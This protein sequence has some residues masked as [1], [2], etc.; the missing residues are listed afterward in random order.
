MSVEVGI[1]GTHGKSRK[2]SSGML[3]VFYLAKCSLGGDRGTMGVY[4]YK[5]PRV[6]NLT[7]NHSMHF[8]TWT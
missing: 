6:I 3:A 8:T 5:T 4:I 2:E 1:V 7:V